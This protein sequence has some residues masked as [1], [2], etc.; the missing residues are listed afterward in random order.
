MR[1]AWI[2][3]C[4]L[5]SNWIDTAAAAQLN[6]GQQFLITI[7]VLYYKYVYNENMEFVN[8]IVIVFVS[9]IYALVLVLGYTVYQNNPTRASHKYFLAL[10]ISF[11][12]WLVCNSLQLIT[13]QSAAIFFLYADYFIAPWVALSLF[14]FL[15]HVPHHAQQI[16]QLVRTVLVA[17]TT[18]L[19]ILVLAEL[20]ITRVTYNGSVPVSEAGPLQILYGIVLLGYVLSGIVVAISHYTSSSKTE[21]SQLLVVLCSTVIVFGSLFVIN[22]LFAS[23]IDATIQIVLNNLALLWLLFIALG[24]KKYLFSIKNFSHVLIYGLLLCIHAGVFLGAYKYIDT[25]TLGLLS[26]DMVFLVLFAVIASPIMALSYN[27]TCSW[28]NK[29]LH[30]NQSLIS[31][32]KKD[33]LEIHSKDITSP[34]DITDTIDNTTF[35]LTSVYPLWFLKQ[36]NKWNLVHHRQAEDYSDINFDNLSHAV[37]FYNGAVV[38]SSMSKESI[39]GGK[40]DE[41][42][43]IMKKHNIEVIYPL[44]IPQEESKKMFG[45]LLIPNDSPFLG[46]KEL[47]YLTMILPQITNDLYQS[48][49]D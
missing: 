48:S 1:I 45:L 13:S 34:T 42:I 21:R 46:S 23:H 41:L 26:S 6:N 30:K 29:I 11:V 40:K 8:E 16:P 10:S 12:L 31:H 33:L 4:L 19:S 24:I 14:F 44:Y 47:N 28:V 38:A 15:V 9:V 18:N 7:L 5:H 39:P 32:L 22:L 25:K 2:L 43:S 3:V 17:A 36:K 37:S 49:L 35:A 20:I 27:H